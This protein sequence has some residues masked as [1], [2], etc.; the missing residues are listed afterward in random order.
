LNRRIPKWNALS[1]QIHFGVWAESGLLHW[2]GAGS[3]TAL[4]TG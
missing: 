4:N 3:F 1:W 2:G